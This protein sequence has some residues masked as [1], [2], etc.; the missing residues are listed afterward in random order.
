MNTFTL[1]QRALDATLDDPEKQGLNASEIETGRIVGAVQ[2]V[3]DALT[4]PDGGRYIVSFADIATAQTS[5][6]ERRIIVSSKPLRDGSL[7]LVEKAVVIAT[8][9]A[10]EIGHTLVTR[11]RRDLVEQHNRHSGFH[12]VANLADDIILEPVMVDRFPILAD[13]FTF[14]GEW[15]LRAT[16]KQPLPKQHRLTADMTTADRF[17]L[18]LS[19]TRYGDIADIVFADAATIAERDWSRAWADRLIAAPLDD[20][21]TFL[22]ICDEAW[23]RVR[24]TA[25]VEPEPEIE[26]EPVTVEVDAEESD[27]DEDGDGEDGEQGDPGESDEDEQD[28][29]PGESEGDDEDGDGGESDDD[30][31]EGDDTTD[32]DGEGESDTESDTDESSDEGDD[33]GDSDGESDGEGD[34]DGDD[35]TDGDAN[36]GPLDFDED[37]DGDESDGT[38]GSGESDGDIGED[39]DATGTDPADGDES[40]DETAA[41]NDVP[42]DANGGGGNNTADDAPLRDEDDFDKDEVDESMHDSAEKDPYDWDGQRVE[43]AVRTYA[44]TTVTA[45]GRHGSITTTW[46]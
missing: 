18:L 16:A 12:A 17:N 27:E 23:D 28:G 15:V 38:D 25:D 42:D 43:Q 8:F 44:S 30:T 32:G 33:E 41:G 19:A 13:A 46:E 2:T 34:E 20:H 39:S 37:N 1:V 22:A 40:D 21:D 36:D 9:A 14:T 35:A 4:P 11:P 24:S 26:V 7:S 6:G 5:L 29:D 45:F 31:D 3:V 10:H